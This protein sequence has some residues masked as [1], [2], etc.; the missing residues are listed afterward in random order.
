MTSKKTIRNNSILYG[1]SQLLQK[2]AAFLV[3]PLVA[4]QLGPSLYGEVSFLLSIA[5]FGI[6]LVMFSIDESTA[7][8]YIVNLG[9]E[10]RSRRGLLSSGVASIFI[11]FLLVT[12]AFVVLDKAY[13]ESNVE[14]ITL[15]LVIFYIGTSAVL[16]LN[17]KV[18]RALDKAKGFFISSVTASICQSIM[19]IFLVIYINLG[20]RGFFLAYSLGALSSLLTSLFFLRTK[21]F[22][23]PKVSTVCYLFNKAKGLVFH[24]VS[25]WF[26]ISFS[27]FWVGKHFD[28]QTTGSYSAMVTF[29]NL[30]FVLISI[31]QML[32][33]PIVYK[34]LNDNEDEYVNSLFSKTAFFLAVA[35][36]ILV[37]LSPY[38]FKF[39][40]G[41]EFRYDFDTVFCLVIFGLFS[42]INNVLTL[43]LYYYDK[44]HKSLSLTTMVSVSVN[45]IL[46]I[47][48]SKTVGV[49]GVPAGLIFSVILAIAIKIYLLRSKTK[50]STRF[51]SRLLLKV[52]C[53]SI[54]TYFLPLKLFF[55]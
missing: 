11:A 52:L 3:L 26:L 12:I 5:S 24:S 14:S 54:V 38:L 50:L 46:V 41:D 32:L 15:S 39:V 19:L 6:V 36:F 53:F 31:S 33:H 48:L 1:A 37:S 17:Y 51:H 34:K 2:G 18:L 45:V 7:R 49:F 29:Y 22:Q 44:L 10:L 42:Y 35:S 25:G 13:L 40:F 23:V 8:A 55:S 21:V 43:Y 20:T 9:S 28:M 16:N 30:F 47:Y 4:K 27:V